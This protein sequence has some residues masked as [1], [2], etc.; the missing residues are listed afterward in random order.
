MNA[1]TREWMSKPRCGL[2][3]IVIN[4]SNT[5]SNYVLQG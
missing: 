1:E 2:P 3:D 4:R 5:T